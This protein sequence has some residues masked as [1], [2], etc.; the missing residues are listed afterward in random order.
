MFFLEEA[1]LY[2]SERGIMNIITRGRHVGIASMFMTNSPQKIPDTVFRQLDNLFL[3]ALTH[4]DD[5]RNVSKNA[6]TDEGT[7]ESFASR[8][9]PG[10]TLIIGRV[11]DRYPIIV[12]VDSLPLGVSPTGETRTTWERLINEDEVRET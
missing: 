10:H 9:P 6:F 3:Q 1:H 4:K 12:E 8:M 5:I 11:T 2:T 7:I